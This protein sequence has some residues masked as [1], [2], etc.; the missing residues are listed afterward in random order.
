M[1]LILFIL[2]ITYSSDE[3][4][5]VFRHGNI[6][7]LLV[8]EVDGLLF[9]QFVHFRVVLRTSVERRES[10]NH[11]VCQNTKGP[12]V[13]REGV[14]TLNQNLRS[15]V[16][17][18]TAEW[19]CLLVAFNDFCEAEICETDISVLVHQDVFRFQVTIDDILFVQMTQ[20]HCHLDRVEASA[21]F[22]ESCNLS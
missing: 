6:V 11:F 2:I 1:L 19:E 5:A 16:I 13:N 21:L 10:D 20:S 22:W 17:W 4:F 18:G 14:A 9:D 12:P 8:R 15:Q 3:V 7:S